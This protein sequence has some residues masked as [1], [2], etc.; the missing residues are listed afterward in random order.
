MSRRQPSRCTK[1]PRPLAAGVLP[2]KAAGAAKCNTATRSAGTSAT[3]SSGLA[4]ELSA[5]GAIALQHLKADLRRQE[6]RLELVA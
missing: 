3:R 6:Q 4:R 5:E 2:Q 1:A